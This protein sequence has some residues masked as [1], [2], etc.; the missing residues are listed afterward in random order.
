MSAQKN[1]RKNEKLGLCMFADAAFYL[2]FFAGLFH[3]HF[4]SQ[5]SPDEDFG[6]CIF[7]DNSLCPVQVVTL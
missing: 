4:V 7:Y 3:G 2:C 5:W 1:T 6:C